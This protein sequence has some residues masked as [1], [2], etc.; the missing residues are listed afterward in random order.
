MPRQHPVV[1]LGRR[2]DRF[3]VIRRRQ[4]LTVPHVLK[5][6][7]SA[8]EHVRSHDVPD[9]RWGS[10]IGHENGDRQPLKTGHFRSRK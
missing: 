2:L 1:P 8:G 10:E 7:I 4:H 6:S 9:N 5:P 3:D